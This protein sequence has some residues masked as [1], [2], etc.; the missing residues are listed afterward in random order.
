MVAKRPSPCCDERRGRRPSSPQRPIQRSQRADGS[1]LLPRR[2]RWGAIVAG[3]AV[4]WGCTGPS[5]GD[6]SITGRGWDTVWATSRRLTDTLIPSPNLMTYSSGR[7]FVYDNSL[8]RVVALDAATGRPLWAVGRMGNGPNEL[9]GIAA[10]LP[11]REGGVALVDIRNRRITRIDPL[12]QF[13]APVP[14]TT[15]GQQPNQ[16]CYMKNGTFVVADVFQPNLLAMTST[17]ELIERLGPIWL[18][19][20]SLA[21]ESRHVLLRNDPLGE[22]CLVALLTGRGFAI[23]TPDL[24][25]RTARY[26]EPFDVHGLGERRSEGDVKFS[27][28]VDAEFSGDTLLVLFSGRTKEKYRLI[29]RFVGVEG[30]YLDTFLLPFGTDEMAAGDGQVFVLDPEQTGVV[31]LRPRLR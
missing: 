22:R 28:I 27:A 2:R 3:L 30:R 24:S 10:I 15:I 19:V 23:V 9:A 21:M 25:T 31:A 18:D 6:R 7:L 29:D 17:G 1:S 4:A 12:G 14:V 26:V 5:P 20:V 8:S 13:S 16:V 11:D